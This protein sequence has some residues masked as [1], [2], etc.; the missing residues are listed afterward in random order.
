MCIRRGWVVRGL[1]EAIASYDIH[2]VSKGRG[3]GSSVEG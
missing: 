1:L 3:R 2:Y